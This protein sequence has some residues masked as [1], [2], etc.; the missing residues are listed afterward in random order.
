MIINS[1][2]ISLRKQTSVIS[3]FAG[4]GGLDV[5]SIVSASSKEAVSEY[6]K[7]SKSNNP[8]LWLENKDA[9]MSMNEVLMPVWQDWDLNKYYPQKIKRFDTEVNLN[10]HPMIGRAELMHKIISFF[11]GKGISVGRSFTGD[12]EVWIPSTDR[13]NPWNGKFY[14]KYTI[15]PRYQDQSTGWELHVMHS[16]VA[17]VSIQPMS[18]L[19]D[20]P[21][22]GYSIM[23]GKEVL[24]VSK[25]TPRHRRQQHNCYPIANRNIKNILRLTPHYE[26]DNNKLVTK[27]N[28]IDGFTKTYLLSDDFKEVVGIDYPTGRWMDVPREDVNIVPTDARFLEYADG[29][30]GLNPMNDLPQ[31]GPYQMPKKIV[32][33][34][35]IFQKDDSRSQSKSAM[36]L[37]NALTFGADT[38]E[39]IRIKKDDTDEKC[40]EK[41]K[42]QQEHAFYSMSEF[43]GQPFSIPEGHAFIFSDLSTSVEEVKHQ[44]ER[45]SKT[46]KPEYTYEAIYISPIK[47][48]D[49]NADA[50][51]V[52]YKLKEMLMERSIMLQTIYGQNPYAKRFNM[53]IPNLSLAMF[54]KAGGTPYVLHKP[55]GDDDLII[56]VGA[57]C[58][59]K[60]GQRYVGSAICFDNKGMLQ[61]YNCWPDCDTDRLKN[62]IKQGIIEFI[63]DHGHNPKRVIIHYYKTMSR[64][65]AR[66][67]TTML[68]NLGLQ[69][70][71]VFVLN[72]NKTE[73]ENIVAFSTEET[74]LMPKSG[75][76]VN[77]GKG[78]YLLYNNSK[79]SS[80]DSA[81]VLY[82]VKIRITKVD[83]EGKSQSYTDNEALELL[84][85][86]YQFSRLSYKTVKQQNMPVTTLYPELAA[87][88]VPFFIGK[89]IPEAG[90]KQMGF[91]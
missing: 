50:L 74:N 68:Y 51:I 65:E 88:I 18:D 89:C 34:I 78:N 14:D 73:S 4:C 60:V 20:L 30:K 81:N 85:Q 24:S 61:G 90:Q 66:P 28:L 29:N 10:N 77:L 57:Y 36:K 67:I 45:L 5:S 42:K 22:N 27:F 19:P 87:R 86:V 43:I 49:A 9:L 83:Q 35:M 17:K 56:G 40:M 62:S 26:Y 3:L 91:L 84:T 38:D 79:Y 64:K 15:C 54:A 76:I 52:Y 39:D 70:V 58:N 31:Y 11:R 6:K 32:K 33:F 55:Y 46:M 2:E 7:L 47:Q 16:G 59:Q 25:M 21:E 72:I 1:L 13:K 75:T 8:N 41:R 44:L 48:D 82:P 80:S 63:R 23:V 53:F 71:S 37:F 69:G 12:P